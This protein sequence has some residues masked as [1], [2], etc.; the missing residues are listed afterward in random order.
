MT[1]QNFQNTYFREHLL[2]AAFIRFRSTI[3][4]HILK[5]LKN[6]NAMDYFAAISKKN[7]IFSGFYWISIPV[8]NLILY[9]VWHLEHDGI[10]LFCI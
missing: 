10:M 4:E 9:F 7:S 5:N 3:S 2:V 6:Y 8:T 1:C